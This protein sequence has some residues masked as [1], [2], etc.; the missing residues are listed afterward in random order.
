MLTVIFVIAELTTTSLSRLPS[1]PAFISELR[2]TSAAGAGAVLVAV[3]NALSMSTSRLSI[4][5]L[6]FV[7][8][9]GTVTSYVPALPPPVIT[10][11]NLAASSRTPTTVRGGASATAA[12]SVLM[13]TLT[14]FNNPVPMLVVLVSVEEE[15]PVGIELR[16]NPS[17]KAMPPVDLTSSRVSLL[18]LPM[19][20]RSSS[21]SVGNSTSKRSPERSIV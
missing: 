16:S 9:A 12:G 2:F 3:S 14:S 21:K 20:D 17:V 13:S 4:V 18:T 5:V 11:V 19:G 10:M 15:P 8:A 1:F 7:L 6:S